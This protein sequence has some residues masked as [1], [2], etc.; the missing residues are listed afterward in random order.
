MENK[1]LDAAL[2]QVSRNRR[3]FLRNLLIGAGAA[4]VAVPLISTQSMAQKDGEDP[5]DGKCDPGLVIK[6]GNGKCSV[7]KKKADDQ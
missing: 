1:H 7:R 6:K 3:G 4:V 5:V 2:E